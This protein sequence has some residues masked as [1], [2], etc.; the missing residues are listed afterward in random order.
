MDIVITRTFVGIIV[1]GNIVELNPNQKKAVNT[2]D[3]N[4]AVNA[5]AGSGKT[6]VLV[7]RY[8]YLLENGNIPVG[9]EIESIV[10]ITFTV[11]A[12]QEM[13]ERIREEI[14]NNFSIDK[15]WRRLYRDL[16]KANISTIHS[17]CSKILRENPIEANIDP[18]FIVLEEYEANKM[19]HETI[20]KILLE[21]IENRIDVYEFTGSFNV[22]NLD[23]LIDT[24]MYLYQKIRSTGMSFEEVGVITIDNIE[25]ITFDEDTIFHIKE[26]LEYLIP[27][28]R[29]N[30]KL[31]NLKQ[32]P[33]WISF[34]Q[35]VEYD[36][37]ILDTLCYLKGNIGSMKSEAERIDSLKEDIDK[38]LLVK[39]KQKLPLYKTLISLLIEIDN[40]YSKE[41]N[42]LGYLDY[43]D[44]QLK[45]SALLDIEHIRRRY[46]EKFKYIMVDE[47]QDTNELQRQII[48]KLTSKEN[49]LDRQNL[50]I[51][52]DPKQSIYGF[53]GADVDVFYDVMKDIESASNMKPISLGENYRS[54]DTLIEFVNK[55]FDKLMPVYEPLIPV[56]SSPNALDVEILEKD[57]I[58]IPEG[59]LQGDYNKYYESRLAAKRI[60]RLVEEEGYEYGDIAIL[61]RS[62]TDDYLYEDAFREYGIPYYN[63]GGKGFFRQEEIVDL[64][65]GIKALSNIYDDIS[66]VGMLRSPMFGLSDE[67]IYWILRQ[68]EDCI[69]DA[70]KN[71]NHYID[72]QER[73][74]VKSAYSTLSILNLKVDLLS[75]Y[76]L[77]KE[78]INLTKYK[79]VL[80]LKYGGMQRQANVNKFLEISR[81]YT[82]VESGTLSDFIDYLDELNS[83]NVDE[84][85]AKIESEDGDSVKL[86]TIHKSKGLQFKVVII[87][88]MAKGFN[89]DRS[90][91][92]FDKNIGLGIRC[93]DFSPLYDQIKG[94]LAIK[95]EEENIR[96][97]YVAMTRA[98][99]KL[100]LGTQGNISGFKKFIFKFLDFVEYD[101]IEEIDID[102][103]F[104]EEVKL[105][106]DNLF[107]KAPFR[108]SEFPLMG[109]L[110]GYN[111]KSFTSFSIT[112]YLTFCECK[113]KFF[114]SYYRR[115]P[116]FE[117]N[118][119]YDYNIN[120]NTTLEP[121]LRGNIVHKFCELYSSHLDSEE[122]LNNI[123]IS[124]GLKPK[125]DVVE[126]L[127]P[128]IDN[129]LKLYP[130]DYD[131][132]YSEKEFYYHLERG[133]IHGII[134]RIYVRDGE[135]EV[136]DFKT[137]RVSNGA[138]RQ[139]IKEKYSPQLQLYAQVCRDT[140]GLEVIRAT[141]LL[142]DCGEYL[143][144]DISKEKVEN[145]ILS[146]NDFMEFVLNYNQIESYSRGK[147]CS[148][149]CPYYFLCN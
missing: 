114:M 140:L 61:F 116:S 67:T 70:L 100:I 27:K 142:L 6:R 28:G 68:G 82:M 32:D 54:L 104:T 119:E 9:K 132:I 88:Q 52:G 8:L 34:S 125:K 29:K 55:I 86:M 23:G 101:L 145:N 124:Y 95:D 105:I 129:Y 65:N 115:L 143:D 77:I 118:K 71:P 58:E 19:L 98:K 51:V 46:Q 99:E 16:E 15:K 122:L 5:G 141:L 108:W 111:Q 56:N 39:E 44:L 13:K 40:E 74:K 76:E 31:S 30:S 33:K 97:L 14:R 102:R 41:K 62:T 127:L 7:E 112:Q 134:D 4:V 37:T 43:E 42:S 107:E 144:V 138:D 126:V 53:R 146:I 93:G 12:S 92:L 79:E 83:G 96:I 128:Y 49:P 22:Y 18:Q 26:E 131:T 94:E 20:K 36:E 57:D 123:I 21:G 130:S 2:I 48:Y 135:I 136:I 72:G 1:G 120:S 25:Y 11:K 84:P 117:Y 24:L 85:Q 47:F 87:P 45:T 139:Y 106:D 50:F 113:R 149:Y 133:I 75:P 73:E 63:L 110:P 69:L 38:V 109:N 103:E 137:N 91:I 3:K 80:L 60:K 64:Y 17:F 78:L 59:N 148:K 89:T 35:M 81:N 90:N 121:I 66:M 10:A 147:N